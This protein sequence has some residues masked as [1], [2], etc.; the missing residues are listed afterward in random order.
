MTASTVYWGDFDHLAMLF[1]KD[2]PPDNKLRFR[3]VDGTDHYVFFD[4]EMVT[5]LLTSIPSGENAY[6]EVP[7]ILRGSVT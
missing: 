3:D 5:T 4:G 1:D 7:I 2:T 6:M